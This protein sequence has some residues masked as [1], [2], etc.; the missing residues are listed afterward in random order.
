MFEL[1]DS[2]VHSVFMTMTSRGRF[3]R[4]SGSVSHGT[5]LFDSTEEL[6]TTEEMEGSAV[7]EEDGFLSEAALTFGKNT[8]GRMKLLSD[9]SEDSSSFEKQTLEAKSSS[10]GS[11]LFKPDERWIRELLGKGE[12]DLDAD[13]ELRSRLVSWVQ[14]YVGKLLTDGRQYAKLANR[15]MITKSDIQLAK[16]LIFKDIFEA[17]QTSCNTRKTLAKEKNSQPFPTIKDERCIALPS[18]RHCLL[19]PNFRI[20]Q[21]KLQ[22]SKHIIVPSTA[23]NSS[24]TRPP[25]TKT[26]VAVIRYPSGVATIR[27]TSSSP[28]PAMTPIT[29]RPLIL[30]DIT[31]I[32]A[33]TTALQTTAQPSPV[34]VAA[35]AT[36]TAAAAAA[37]AAGTTTT[38]TTSTM[39][40]ENLLAKTS[41]DTSFREQGNSSST[42]V[43]N[44]VSVVP[45]PSSS[46][47]NV[48]VNKKRSLFRVIA[49][50]D[51]SFNTS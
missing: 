4:E 21:S 28:V 32:A 48:M 1:Q 27:S 10:T 13:Q 34:V 9:G 3:S 29:I 11:S 8:C 2:G 14:N 35:A 5:D 44:V 30:R 38:T 24:S 46:A 37:A 12:S 20:N 47:D 42:G 31:A 6:S 39:R 51:N 19:Q 23:S 50:S 49:G 36:A 17:S 25:T 18:E 33:A 16:S 41:S 7:E 43:S 45:P 26:N 22:A 40:I 15:T